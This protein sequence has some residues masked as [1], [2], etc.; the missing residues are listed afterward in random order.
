VN[1]KMAHQ[2]AQEAL[3]QN[4]ANLWGRLCRSTALKYGQRLTREDVASGKLA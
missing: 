1:I 4:R 3:A 2:Q